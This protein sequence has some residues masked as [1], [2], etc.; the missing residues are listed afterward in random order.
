M[1]VAF[2][3]LCRCIYLLSYLLTYLTLPSDSY[4]QRSVLI[5]TRQGSASPRT[6]L[7]VGHRADLC[8]L[9]Y[10]CLHG[11]ALWYPAESSPQ[12]SPPR[13][14]FGRNETH[15]LARWLINL[16]RLCIST[17]RC[18]GVEQSV[19]SRSNCSLKTLLQ[20]LGPRFEDH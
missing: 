19:I 15:R 16:G 3:A 14:Y 1:A 10:R 18:T 4:S 12:R 8:V 17:R 6:S 20:A 9:T 5:S 7:V 11:T 2:T 13:P